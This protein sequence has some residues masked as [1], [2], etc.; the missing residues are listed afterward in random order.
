MKARYLNLLCG[1]GGSLIAHG[2]ASAAFVGLTVVDQPNEFGILACSVYAVFDS[3]DDHLIAVAG[4][5]H[6]PLLI[7]ASGSFYQTPNVGTDMAP[8]SFLVGI[9]PSL[10][11]DTFVSIGVKLITEDTVDFTIA[12]GARG[13]RFPNGW[14]GFGPT[15]LETDPVFGG[16]WFTV[17]DEPQGV[18]DENG[19]VFLGQF[20]TMDATRPPGGHM[21]I[22]AIS[23]GVPTLFAASFCHSLD[24]TPCIEGDT[25]GDTFVDIQDFLAVIG[26]WGQPPDGVCA[27]ADVDRDGE[28]GI[29][30]FLLILGRWT[31]PP[32]VPAALPEDVDADLTGDGVVDLLD[33]TIFMTYWCLANDCDVDNDGHEGMRDLLIVLA[34]LDCASYGCPD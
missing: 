18:P 2:P 3:P 33:L 21:V 13:P 34:N 25:N 9:F 20:S 15:R 30:D 32:A 10:E 12:V 31:G 29:S 14:P 28:T 23:D 26:C 4:T 8:S 11:F 5:Q 6:A 24:G 7:E 1:V 19:L 27:Y 17:P 16:G 22:E